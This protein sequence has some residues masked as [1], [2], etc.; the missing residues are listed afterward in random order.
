MILNVV[1]MVVPTAALVGR[2]AEGVKLMV[3]GGG[4]VYEHKTEGQFPFCP[5]CQMDIYSPPCDEYIPH[6]PELHTGNER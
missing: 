2:R 6:L 1:N 4:C 3:S 5:G